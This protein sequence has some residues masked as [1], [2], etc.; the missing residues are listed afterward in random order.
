LEEQFGKLIEAAGDMNSDHY[1]MTVM[2]D[3]LVKTNIT[4]TQV[5]AVINSTRQMDSDHYITEVLLDAAPRVKAGA[6]SM[7]DAYRSAAKTIS[8]ETY[9]GRAIR[10]ID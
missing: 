10:A 1:K 4:D 8:S 2:Q 3:A 5:V 7:K 6:S 9:Y